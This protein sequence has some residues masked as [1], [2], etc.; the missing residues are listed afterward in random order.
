MT[1]LVVR[2]ATSQ[3]LEGLLAIE[4][5]F[6]EE[7]S[8]WWSI[9]SRDVFEFKVRAGSLIVAML[10]ERVVGYIMWTLFWGW[11]FVEYARVLRDDRNQGIGTRML[12]SLAR[13]AAARGH[14][15]LWSSTSDPDALRWHERNGFTRIGEIQWVWG[16]TR[17]TILNKDLDSQ[18]GAGERT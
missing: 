9:M 7:G 6:R 5:A 17:E 12:D 8:P 2:D 18:A 16:R 11:P 4:E 3:D 15:R 1:G 13:D 10:G 14:Q